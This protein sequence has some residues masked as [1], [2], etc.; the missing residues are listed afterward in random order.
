MFRPFPRP[1][2]ADTVAN[3]A[4]LLE[5]REIRKSFSAGPVLHGVDFSIQAGE[6]H[7]LVGHNGA[8]KSTLMKA[9]AGNFVDYGGRIL[10]KGREYKLHT[11]ADALSQG[12]A[13]IYQ[14]FA[15]VPDLSVAANIALGREPAGVFRGLMPHKALRV[16]SAREA[17]ALAIDLPMDAPIRKLGV[18]AQ[19]LTEIVRACSQEVCILV[20]DEPTARLAPAEREH[21]FAVMR[22]MC[23]E[24]G[25]GIIYIS[26]F[27]EEVRAIADRVT[28][29]RDGNV[30]ESNHADAY[31]VEDL[32][33]L[34]VGTSDI[35][36][37]GAGEGRRRGVRP[38]AP[39]MLELM[40][41]S[42]A[43]RPG[44]HVTV[45]AGEILG[46][47]GLV[48]SGRTRLARA[49][50]GDV[51]SAGRVRLDGRELTRRSPGRSA[52]AGL[53]MVPEDRKISGLA[54][55]ASIEQNIEVT[56][57]ARSLSR[58]G[59]VLRSKRRKI[60]SDLIRTFRIQPP[61]HAMPVGTLSGGNAQK[62]LLARA[63]AA[64]PR[65]MIL[66]QPTAGV[67]IGAKSELHKLI[68]LAAEEGTAVILISDDLDE[69]LGLSD[70]IMVMAE[71][72]LGSPMP[73]ATI[74]RAKLLA[75]ISRSSK[76]AT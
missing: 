42:V 75:A 71:G 66:D 64:R 34:L 53:V 57:L 36:L 61:D 19:Q 26:H 58:A 13:I 16:R 28:I 46:L 15:L 60:V 6:I 69:L 47:A 72:V 56:A 37:P 31:S 30:V 27:L 9:L 59:I 76:T 65:A 73:Q 20:M 50:V 51:V 35:V 74:D 4:M 5:M 1:G 7:A 3:D 32:A 67:D 10:I 45:A 68:A 2:A 38:G 52:A 8:G 25:V 18:A 55:A 22:R 12:V 41:L 17:A 48:G 24:K 63:V 14:D 21:L 11:P 39:P 44:V 62:V 49:I 29:M 43:G 70:R 23:R 33:R 54:L 40:D